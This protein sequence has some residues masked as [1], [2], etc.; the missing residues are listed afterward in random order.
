V[1]G[2]QGGG[3]GWDGGAGFLVDVGGDDVHAGRLL[4]GSRAVAGTASAGGQGLGV[5]VDGGGNDV[6]DPS[7][8]RIGDAS[9][10]LVEY[11][12]PGGNFAWLGLVGPGRRE[13]PGGAPEPGSGRRVPAVGPDGVAVPFGAGGVLTIERG[14]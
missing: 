3:Y 2:S 6:F 1:V 7:C 8:A 9:H 5:V 13:V 12:V 4:D 14:D 10:Y 11:L